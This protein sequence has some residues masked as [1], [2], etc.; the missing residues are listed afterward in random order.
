[1]GSFSAFDG[2][3]RASSLAAAQFS[4]CLYISTSP[5]STTSRGEIWKSAV[6]LRGKFK[7]YEYQSVILPIIVIRRLEC[8]L[9]QWREE[10]AAEIRKERPKITDEELAKLVKNLELNPQQCP[11][12]NMTDWTL[13][14]V[15]EE[16]QTLLEDNYRAYINGFSEN[17]QDVIEHF[18]Y[19]AT[20]LQPADNVAKVMTAAL[21]A[22]EVISVEWTHRHYV[23]DDEYIPHGEDSP[24][25]TTCNS[26]GTTSPCHR[27]PSS[28]PSS[29]ILRLS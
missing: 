17:I 21:G 7:A 28:K 14:K 18:N 15:M 4:S 10:K 12:S 2:I 6:R 23:K 20:T 16:D 22:A 1:M 29:N 13:H 3:A 11:F 9:I 26:A 19:R 27:F 8:V 5:S 24:T 25:S